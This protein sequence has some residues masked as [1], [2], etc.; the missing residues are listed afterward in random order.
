MKAY[1]TSIGEPT[2]E[3]CI[4]A[5][6]RN[7]FETLLLQDHETSLA[8]KLKY[9]YN[10]AE[11][12]FVRVDADVVVNQEFTPEFVRAWRSNE[13]WWFQFLCF[14][15]FQ[16]D[17][18]YG[19]V[20]YIKAEALPALRANVDKFMDAER[21]E[22]ELSRI[23]EF[24]NPRRFGSAP[25]LVGLNNYKNDIARVRATKERRNQTGYDWDLAER[26][27]RL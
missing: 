12:D 11:E 27:E 2:T 19:G 21:P 25:A 22:T 8:T 10:K 16:Q 23:K 14:D 7:G 26:L 18:G 20:Q 13:E 5:L 1:I 3:L 6:Q 24:Y 9:I 17:E 4:W 15:W